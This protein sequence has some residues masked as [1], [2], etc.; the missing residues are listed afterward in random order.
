MN[1]NLKF[2]QRQ[3]IINLKLQVGVLLYSVCLAVTVGMA[4]E[5][6]RFISSQTLSPILGMS[7]FVLFCGFNFLL[8]TSI[9]LFGLYFTN[10][11]AGP[12]YRLKTHIDMINGGGEITPF[13][14]RS[15]DY[16]KELM[17]SYNKLLVEMKRSK[18]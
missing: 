2:Y 9:I 17:S 14:L 3:Y 5:V 13:S 8:L 15:D 4:S 7:P 6:F 11:I 16:F 12:I 18:E 1:P 10:R